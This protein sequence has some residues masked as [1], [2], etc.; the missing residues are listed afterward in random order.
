LTT[1]A[2]YF[3]VEDNHNAQNAT[4]EPDALDHGS[5]IRWRLKEAVAIPDNINSTHNIDYAVKYN[6]ETQTISFV[7]NDINAL[8]DVDVNI[9]TVG[10][11]LLY[12]FKATQTQSLAALPS[13]TYIVS[14]KYMDKL[15]SV[16]FKK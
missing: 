16:K 12:T 9:Y 3:G 15:H 11:R 6:K 1:V 2:G 7:S 8:S 4:L 10:G 13:G 14:W 5:N